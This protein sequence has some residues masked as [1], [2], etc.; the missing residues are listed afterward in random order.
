MTTQSV[1]SPPSSKPIQQH[2]PRAAAAAEPWSPLQIK[3]QQNYWQLS[4][5]LVGCIVVI[6]GF[7]GCALFAH[8]LAPHDP[9]AN[10]LVHRLKPPAWITGSD[11]TYPLGTDALGRDVLSRLIYGAR[12]SLAI[13]FI[14]TLIGVII[15][16]LSGLLAGYIG[17]H[18][19]KH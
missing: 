13:G 9:I 16:G 15:G 17:G 5:L 11:P 14:G 12:V 1:G 4:P 18:L 6:F 10:N 19:M 2:H 7:A 3:H 8:W